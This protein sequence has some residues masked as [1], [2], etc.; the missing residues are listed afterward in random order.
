MRISTN[1]IFQTGTNYLLDGQ[2]NLFNIQNKLGTGKKFLSASENPVAA[3]QAL[4]T[5][6][7][8][9]VNAQYAENQA[10]AKSQLALEEDRLKSVVDSI[11]FV[12][13]QTVAAGNGTYSDGQREYIA[14]G[15]QGQLEFLVGMANSTD[16]NGYYLFSGF[17]GNTKPFQAIPQAGGTIKYQY[18]GDDGQRLLQV[19]SSRQIAVSD[20]G[21]DIF[22]RIRTGNGTFALTG[23]PGNTG[24]STMGKSSVN[25]QAL[26]TGNNYEIEFTSATTYTITETDPITSAVIGSTSN[27]YVS[28]AEIT[29]IPGISFSIGGEPAVGDTYNVAPSRDQSLFVTLQNLVA[30]IST[31]FENNPAQAANAKNIIAAEMYNLQRDLENTS[32]M[33]ASIGNRR[34]EL[35]SLSEVSSAL[36]LHYKERLSELQDLDYAQAISD[37]MRQQMQLE[38]AQS[39]FAKMTSLSLFQ[40]I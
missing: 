38:A 24:S 10:N 8:I 18:A 15:I 14:Q 34:F 25:N 33:Q 21:R 11:L 1:Q 6:Q 30:A 7:S 22:E 27:S 36:E 4:L 19:G 29:D 26:W 37:F 2:S 39:S 40:Y 32:T 9:G 12:M 17:Q 35:D 13:E 5:S 20:S 3:T 16:A 28:G 31:D 23:D